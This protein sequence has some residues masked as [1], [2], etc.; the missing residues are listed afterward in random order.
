MDDRPSERFPIYTRGNTGE[1]YPNVI[2]P[3]CGSIV[4]QPIALGQERVF[5]LGPGAFDVDVPARTP[6]GVRAA[7]DGDRSVVVRWN[8]G[9]EPDLIGTIS[10]YLATVT[11]VPGTDL[12][13]TDFDVSPTFVDKTSPDG[14]WFEVVHPEGGTYRPQATPSRPVGGAR[15]APRPGPTRRL[16]LHDHSYAE[17]GARRRRPS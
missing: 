3:L 10:R 7:L 13:S 15:A 8:R 9:T 17:R 5:R 6:S 12:R 4:A 11:A 2:T 1:V 14:G 16:V